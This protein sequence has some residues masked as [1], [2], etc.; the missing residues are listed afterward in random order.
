MA[1]TAVQENSSA[2][3]GVNA[4]LLGPPGCGKGT[5]VKCWHNFI[6]R[7]SN[8]LVITFRN[9]DFRLRKLLNGTT[10]V[11]CPRVTCYEQK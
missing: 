5:Q 4:V 1:V 9:V 8:V 11:I 2:P 3:S 7:F 10:Y 6:D